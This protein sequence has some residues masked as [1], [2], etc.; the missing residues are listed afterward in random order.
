M[1]IFFDKLMKVLYRP[2]PYIVELYI[3]VDN[4]PG[5]F[6]WKGMVM[7]RSKPEAER[8]AQDEALKTISIVKL[9]VKRDRSLKS[10]LN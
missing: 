7:A 6:Y 2:R 1:G 3:K 8:L 4:N 10:K 9:S 5:R